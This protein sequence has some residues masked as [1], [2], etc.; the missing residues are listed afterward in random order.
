[1][2][3]KNAA[4]PVDDAAIDKGETIPMPSTSSPVDEAVSAPV[5]AEDEARASRR[6][7]R[8]QKRR[9]RVRWS[10]LESWI[11]FLSFRVVFLS[12]VPHFFF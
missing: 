12:L 4:M 3:I 5:A 2:K 9:D 7:A 1:M 10:V 11:R 8:A 6:A